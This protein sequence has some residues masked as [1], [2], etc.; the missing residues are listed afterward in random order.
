MENTVR[1]ATDADYERVKEFYNSIDNDFF[2]RLS[3]R[4]GGLDKYLRRAIDNGKIAIFERNKNIIAAS[5]YWFENE[6]IARISVTGVAKIYRRSIAL[7]RLIEYMVRQEAKNLVEKVQASTWTGNQNLKP[8]LEMLG[9]RK[10]QTIKGDLSPKRVTEVYEADIK[11]IKE[12]FGV[13]S[14]IS[15]N[16]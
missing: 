16:K 8:I 13:N 3:E 9:F 12:F 10:I 11:D 15:K 7:Y 2:P 4:E 6:N 1:F 14:N 5:S